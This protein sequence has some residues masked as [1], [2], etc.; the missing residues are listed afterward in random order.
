MRNNLK[1]RFIKLKNNILQR[2]IFQKIIFLIFMIILTIINIIPFSSMIS[3]KIL[4]AL[5]VVSYLIMLLFFKNILNSIK[6]ILLSV[7]FIYMTVYFLYAIFSPIQF[8]IDKGGQRQY[9][10]NITDKTMF[11]S[12]LLYF[13]IFIVLCLLLIIKGNIKNNSIW[14]KN[15]IYLRKPNKLNV[16]L[17]IIAFICLVIWL[18]EYLKNGVAIFTYS[19]AVR[20]KLTTFKFQQYIWL[21]MMAYSL[22]YI[23][24]S[25]FKK[26]FFKGVNNKFKFTIIVLFWILSLLVDRRHII[27]VFIGVVLFLIAQNG[28]IKFKNALIVIILVLLLLISSVT[29]MGM[30]LSTISLSDL[31]YTT[32]GEFILTN[33][34]TCYYVANPIEHL[35]LG[36]TYVWHTISR[37]FPRIILPS[38]PE[39]LAMTFYRTVLDS[40]V[41]FAFNPVAEGL[42]NFGYLS[43]L[44][45]PCIFL[46]IIIIA[47]KSRNKNPL[48]YIMISSYSLDFCRGQF[49]NCAFDLLVMFI[50]LKLM[51][52]FEIK[53]DSGRSGMK[54][55][56]V[57]CT[58]NREKELI[59]SINS[60]L[61][62]GYSDIEIIVVDQSE[63][64]KEYI[65]DID[66]RIMYLHSE[67]KGLSRNRNIG[68]KRASG[69]YIC[70]M[71]DD[72]LYAENTLKHICEI[73]SK[74]DP[75]LLGGVI[76]DHKTKEYYIGETKKHDD[77]FISSRDLFSC[78]S[79]AA[80]IFKKKICEKIVF[81]EMLGI[82]ERWG[83]GEEIDF[84]TRAMYEGSKFYFS[85]Q[86]LVYH[87]SSDKR[88]MGTDKAY[89]YSLGFG[90]LCA[91]HYYI[92]SNPFFMWKYKKALL[93][94]LVAKLIYKF[95]KDDYMVEFYEKSYDGKRK[96]FIEYKSL[97]G[98]E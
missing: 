77:G 13:N 33:Y 17:D 97:K 73:I 34:V 22:S 20:R 78:C 76:V 62:Q 2:S 46:L 25:I 21:Y 82:G 52:R 35:F 66:D 16:I 49:A 37:L 87:P 28:R 42:I 19:F 47:N 31:T 50:L 96:G 51:N 10:F 9:Y 89:K 79:S 56:F 6:E 14:F 7:E 53:T 29:R 92:Y 81:D 74:Y 30:K 58:L 48:F 57:L 70:L 85:K 45:T 75:D 24:E 4:V 44:I 95:K 15:D 86:I 26:S 71:D 38:K 88:K 54:F 67:K 69:D 93:K 18:Y 90:A 43:I 60:I 1:N 65:A 63:K 3:I 94:H 64:S 12:T 83:S 27:S 84:V 39:D 40:K 41:G 80:L 8:L 98:K 72:A 61:N 5:F 32:L 91:K 59:D 68:I 55:S 11:L 36:S 23:C